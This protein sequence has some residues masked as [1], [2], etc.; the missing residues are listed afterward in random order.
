LISETT[1]KRKKERVGRD[2]N[3]LIYVKEQ[4][5]SSY[6]LQ[7]KIVEQDGKIMRRF[8]PFRQT[9]IFVTLFFLY[10]GQSQ[11]C[12]LNNRIYECQ[13]TSS[14]STVDLTNSLPQASEYDS[15]SIKYNGNVVLD[16]TSPSTKPIVIA[17]LDSNDH[18]LQI[19][20]INTNAS[21][22]QI[23]ILLSSGQVAVSLFTDS[24]SIIAATATVTVNAAQTSSNADEFKIFA[25]SSTTTMNFANFELIVN[26]TNSDIGVRE[27]RICIFTVF[28]L[29]F[30]FRIY[31]YLI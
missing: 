22:I 3:K 26:A 4:F 20:R 13:A 1:E 29:F 21:S 10:N 2:E 19:S 9:I 11:A 16:L 23:K 31:I 24:S 28:F 30:Y 27:T 12:S 5:F 15:I 17:P 18:K 7:K 6:I 14:S 8:L 25:P